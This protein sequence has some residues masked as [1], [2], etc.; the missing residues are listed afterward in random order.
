MNQEGAEG[1]C[2]KSNGA[3]VAIETVK[4]N[5]MVGAILLTHGDIAA[6]DFWTSASVDKKTWKS[7]GKAFEYTDPTLDKSQ[8]SGPCMTVSWQGGALHWN[9]KPCESYFPLCEVSGPCPATPPDPVPPEQ[10][11]PLGKGIS[12]MMAEYDDHKICFVVD[13]ATQVHSCPCS[14]EH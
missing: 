13:T 9:K 14:H 5:A 3:L 7:T 1:L 8:G 4:E 10:P 6:Q 11:S 12:K 2:K